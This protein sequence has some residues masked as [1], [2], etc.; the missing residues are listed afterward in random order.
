MTITSEAIICDLLQ[1]L[2]PRAM[3]PEDFHW[4]YG[5]NEGGLDWCRRCAE[6]EVKRLKRERPDGHFFVDGGFDCHESDGSAIC[7]KC[8]RLL[9]YSLTDYGVKT[10]INHFAEN[11]VVSKGQR[12]VTPQVAFEVV[13]VL[14]HARYMP[15]EYRWAAIT[16]GEEAVAKLPKRFR[17]GVRSLR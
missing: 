16:V 15:S 9:N 4:I 13:A 6:R 14:E 3:V 1:Q 12:F 5:F 10:E 2:R 7:C 11:G 8:G 17:A